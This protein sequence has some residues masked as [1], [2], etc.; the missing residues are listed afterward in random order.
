MIQGVNPSY[1]ENCLS[2]A[3]IDETVLRGIFQIQSNSA[4]S[5][6]LSFSRAIEEMQYT[7]ECANLLNSS[8]LMNFHQVVSTKLEN[9]MSMIDLLPLMEVQVEDLKHSLNEK[10]VME[11]FHA[12]FEL[13]TEDRISVMA[14]AV[15]VDMRPVL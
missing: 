1:I 3:P 7:P 10:E 13:F 5:G 11:H 14:P 2:S 12:L 9:P 6:L 8:T 15:S 4:Y